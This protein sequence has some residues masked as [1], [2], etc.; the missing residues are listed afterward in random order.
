MT[1]T[2][3]PPTEFQG[4]VYFSWSSGLED[5]TFWVYVDGD[6]MAVTTETSYSF[7]GTAGESYVLEVFDIEDHTPT[8]I[9]GGKAHFGWY[10]VANAQEYRIEQ[11][12]AGEWVDLLHILEDGSG[13]YSWRSAKLADGVLHSFRVRG[14][15]DNA[16]LGSVLE[17]SVFIVR[18]PDPPAASYAYSA[19]TGAITISEA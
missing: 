9:P 4:A 7:Y 10:S 19:G 11:L 18:F 15:V 3:N 5:P 1:V 13:F 16:Y 8:T 6:L 2:L 14:V 17:T 12:V